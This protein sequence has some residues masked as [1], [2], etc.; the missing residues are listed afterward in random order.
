MPKSNNF[1]CNRT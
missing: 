1:F